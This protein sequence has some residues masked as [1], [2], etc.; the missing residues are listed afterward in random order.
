MFAARIRGCAEHGNSRTA[1]MLSHGDRIDIELAAPK[2]A[3][4]N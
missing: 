4:G 1:A 3:A 2:D